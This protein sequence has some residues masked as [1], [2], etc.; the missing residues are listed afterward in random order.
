MTIIKIYTKEN[1]IFTRFV[2]N[3]IIQE[4]EIVLNDD[5][6]MIVSFKSYDDKIICIKKK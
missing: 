3:R 2:I 4:E 5:V 6:E 1:E